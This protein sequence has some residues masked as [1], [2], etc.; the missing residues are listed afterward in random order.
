MLNQSIKVTHG[1][2]PKAT[3]KVQKGKLYKCIQNVIMEDGEI[4]YIKGKVYPSQIDGHITDEEGFINHEWSDCC[5]QDLEECFEEY[6]YH[7]EDKWEERR[8]EIAREMLPYAAETSRSIL[9]SGH[10][11]GDDAK[12]K[13]LAEVC[14]SSAVSFADALI[15]ELHKQPNPETKPEK[16]PDKKEVA[17]G[18]VVEYQGEHLLCVEKSDNEDCSGCAFLAEDD[19]C[20]FSGRCYK[21]C[22]TDG[23]NVIF[24][25][26]GK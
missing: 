7:E 26:G 10:S 2:R 6:E 4:A 9:M 12:G 18:E 21:E 16:Q 5:T 8:Y 24:V 14:A 17:I 3:M 22:R 19:D 20:K 1:K 23:K 11:L 25:K 13:T 15:A